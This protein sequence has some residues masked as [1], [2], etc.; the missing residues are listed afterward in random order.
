MESFTTKDDDLFKE[1]SEIELPVYISPY[2]TT[3][4]KLLT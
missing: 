4:S 1:A 2:F 3:I